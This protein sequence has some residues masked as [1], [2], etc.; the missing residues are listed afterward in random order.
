LDICSDEQT[1]KKADKEVKSYI[2]G[3]LRNGLFA[4]DNFRAFHNGNSL[5]IE[6]QSI[7]AMLCNTSHPPS[8]VGILKDILYCD[9]IVRRFLEQFDNRNLVSEKMANDF[10][11]IYLTYQRVFDGKCYDMD[12]REID[13][14]AIDPVAIDPMMAMT[15]K[16][17]YS[18]FSNSPWILSAYSKSILEKLSIKIEK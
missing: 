17:I 3:I 4:N 2:Q 15:A 10:L 12:Y 5:Y 14:P 8:V 1:P 13:P 9:N 11:L 6:F 7:E 18:D 16:Q